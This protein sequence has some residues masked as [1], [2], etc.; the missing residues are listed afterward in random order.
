MSELKE[1]SVT[2]N[3]VAARV[4]EKGEGAPIGYFP[5]YG[6]APRWH[7]FLDE[8]AK[9]R[10]VIVPSL[11]GFPGGGLGHLKLDSHLDWVLAAGD[12]LD[13]SGLAG[14]D[15]IGV[16]FGG[17][18]AADVAAVLPQKVRRLVLI[19]SYGLYDEKDPITNIWAQR[20]GAAPK[21]L[22]ARPERFKELTA[23]PNDASPVEWPI[24]MV[25][26]TEAGARYLWPFGNT[27]LDRRLGRIKQP[28][29][30]LRGSEDK[31]I[32]AS[33]QQKFAFAIGAS[34]KTQ[35]ING[36]GHLAELDEPEAVA[37]AILDFTE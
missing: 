17:A 7:S 4:W 33:Y 23:M 14:A 34:A 22:C 5:G 12:L 3:G 30:L 15:L 24:E 29:L 2:L 13:L 6:G 21:V 10:R 20:P 11:P 18:L 31:V 19:S 8:L 35:T 9:K 25:R 28:V 32:P 1:R 26:A 37:K 16:G 27:H 36:A